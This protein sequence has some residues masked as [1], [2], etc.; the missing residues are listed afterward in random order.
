MYTNY[1][2]VYQDP[3]PVCPVRSPSPEAVTIPGSAST[4]PTS[5][6]NGLSG[7]SQPSKVTNTLCTPFSL[8]MNLTAYSPVKHQYIIVKLLHQH[9]I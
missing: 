6:L 1:R 9:I 4:L 7:M 8:G 5:T 3:L 2:Y